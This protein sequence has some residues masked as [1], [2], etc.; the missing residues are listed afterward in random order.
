M[1]QKV[2]PILSQEQIDEQLKA[3]ENKT[4]I[5]K[6]YELNKDKQ[7]EIEAELQKKLTK[8][9][10]FLRGKICQLI[11]LRMSPELRFYRD[12][13]EELR[14][15]EGERARKFMETAKE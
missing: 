14:D 12:N 3:V 4:P 11:G 6:V 1:K 5:Q 7:L 2:S 13:T 9:A 15:E 10:P 8:A